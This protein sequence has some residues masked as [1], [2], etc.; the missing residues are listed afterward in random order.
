MPLRRAPISCGLLLMFT[1]GCADMA[2][3]WQH[4]GP[5]ELQRMRA[6]YIDPFPEPDVGPK[7]DGGRPRDFLTPP[8]ENE[9]VQNEH[10]YGNRYNQAPPPGTFRAT[11]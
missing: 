11:R 9:R 5:A 2:P 8:S 7:V 1:S 10:S 4:P 3:F 6:E